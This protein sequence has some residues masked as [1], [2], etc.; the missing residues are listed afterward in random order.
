MGAFSPLFRLMLY[1]RRYSGFRNK[2]DGEKWLATAQGQNSTDTRANM[3]AKKP[4]REE[5]GKKNGGGMLFASGRESHPFM[6]QA[7]I[8]SGVFTAT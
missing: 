5:K 7:G 2:K 4:E 1:I 3:L 6:G 8:L